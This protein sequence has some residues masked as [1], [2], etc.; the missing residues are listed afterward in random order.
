MFGTIQFRLKLYKSST[1]FIVK[2]SSSR[3]TT[4]KLP[5]PANRGS[6]QG[7]PYTSCSHSLGCSPI[8]SA[9][10]TGSHAGLATFPFFPM[11]HQAGRA[12][13][14]DSAPH[15]HNRHIS[16]RPHQPRHSPRRNGVF[17]RYI[18]KLELRPSADFLIVSTIHTHAL[19]IPGCNCRTAFRVPV[20]YTPMARYIGRIVIDDITKVY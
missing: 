20:R 1:S 5:F 13:R 7:N 10:I 3:A 14:G 9:S 18:D 12:S 6:P 2:S 8:Q 15:S 17:P 16:I 11:R 19:R 4:R